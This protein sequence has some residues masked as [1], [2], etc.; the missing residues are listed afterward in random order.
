M[1][2]KLF[3]AIA[4]CAVAAP[5]A[6]QSPFEEIHGDILRKMDVLRAQRS[7]AFEPSLAPQPTPNQLLYDVLHYK[8]DVAID[9]LTLFIEGLV[10]VTLTPLTATLSSVDIDA[11]DALTIAG[12]RRAIG[13]TLVWAR[14]TDL[15]TI[16][17]PPGVSAGDTIDVEILYGGNPGQAASVGLFFSSASGYPLI[18]SLSEPWS[19]RGWW[20]CKDYPDDKATFDLYF[21]VPEPL[22]A[23]SN[24]TYL[25]YNDETRWSA[26][27]HRYHWS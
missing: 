4:L 18:Y 15:I 25:G 16:E 7:S 22:F 20:P 14:S 3:L 9:P 21:S 27:Y 1:V 8:L 11:D 6:A 5:V 23:A 10:Q 2:R 24:G 13:D 12:V 19:A 17:L 26:P